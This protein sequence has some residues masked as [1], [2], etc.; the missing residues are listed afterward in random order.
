MT[1]ERN[2]YTAPATP[3]EECYATEFVGRPASVYLALVLILVGAAIELVSES[4]Y[5]MMRSTEKGFMWEVIW[6]LFKLAITFWMCFHIARR[7]NWARYLLLA[8]VLVNALAVANQ[9]LKSFMQMPDDVRYMIDWGRV[10]MYV[11]PSLL[12]AVAICL[13]FGPARTWFQVR[14]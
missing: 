7:R 2:P 3:V 6:R 8:F 9:L 1:E 14:N 4:G 5:L 10:A 11:A 13:L 12:G